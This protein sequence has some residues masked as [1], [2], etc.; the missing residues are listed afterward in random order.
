M[1]NSFAV[2]FPWFGCLLQAPAAAADAKADAKSDEAKR[3]EVEP[4]PDPAGTT[5]GLNC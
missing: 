5:S 2:P 1:L 3:F 4:Q